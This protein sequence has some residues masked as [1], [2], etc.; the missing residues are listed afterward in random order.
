[1]NLPAGIDY[2]WLAQSKLRRRIWEQSAE[3]CT[4]LLADNPYDQARSLVS[5]SVVTR[6]IQSPDVYGNAQAVW[7]LKARALTL[8]E[9]VDDIE[10]EEEV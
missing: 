6:G 3:L 1:M 2:V 10:V 9:W 5:R 4:K 7:H 8:A